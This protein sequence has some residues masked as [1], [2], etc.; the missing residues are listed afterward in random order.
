MYEP[1]VLFK[2]ISARA[3]L[4]YHSRIIR[5]DNEKTSSLMFQKLIAAKRGGD[6]V[7]NKDLRRTFRPTSTLK[8]F[9]NLCSLLLLWKIGCQAISARMSLLTHDAKVIQHSQGCPRFPCPP[10]LWRTG[11]LVCLF[12]GGPAHQVVKSVVPSYESGSG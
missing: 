5:L 2:A 3:P 4:Y 11:G 9:Q 1:L 12:S 6:C 8:V 7:K 10:F